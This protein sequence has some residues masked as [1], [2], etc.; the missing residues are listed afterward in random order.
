MWT[1]FFAATTAVCAIGLLVM[2]IV[3]HALIIHM[4]REK[5]SIPDEEEIRE[6][7]KAALLMMIRQS[8]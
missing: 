8:H 6:C 7:C 3:N 1:V 5:C 2:R 4:K